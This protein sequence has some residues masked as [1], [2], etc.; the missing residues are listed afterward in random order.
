[1]HG[2]YV[3]YGPALLRSVRTIAG[4]AEAEAVV[5]DVFVDLLRNAE[6]R[7]RYRGGALLAWIDGKAV[8][9]ARYD[10][11]GGAFHV[12]RVSVLPTHRGYGIASIMMDYLE[13]LA[14]TNGYEAMELETRLSLPRNVAL[15]ERLGFQIVDTWQ[16]AAGADVQVAMMKP[17]VD[18]L[19]FAF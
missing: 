15:Y 7:A 12:G 13:Q 14:R 17:L 5:H 9:S 11:H 2:I 16:S 1:M 6:M 19:A 4:P 18:V 8:G 10:I 3:A